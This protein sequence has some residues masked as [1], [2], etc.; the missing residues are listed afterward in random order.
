MIKQIKEAVR[1]K[2][3]LFAL[4]AFLLPLLFY[5]NIFFGRSFGFDCAPGI[6]GK[7]LGYLQ[8]PKE[9]NVYCATIIDPGAY[10]WQHPAQWSDVIRHYL[11]LEAPI[12]TQHIGLGFPLAANFQSGA[13]FILG[14]PFWF[15][16][17][18]SKGNLFHLDMF[19]VFRYMMMS[20]GMYLFLRSFGLRRL[21]CYIGAFLYFNIGYFILIPNI[22]HH[23]VDML[24][25]FVGWA[26]NNLYFSQQ[27]KWVGIGILILGLS[28]LAG[29][30]EASI[31]TLF[32]AG[33]YV[34][35]LSLILS[36]N[37]MKMFLYGSGSIVGALLLASLL[38]LPGLEYIRLGMTIHHDTSSV[39]KSIPT[40]Y[41]ST[42]TFPELFGGEGTRDEG[43]KMLGETNYL[44]QGW[45]YIGFS[46]IFFFI[47]GVFM[48]PFFPRIKER[49]WT[50]GYFFFTGLAI[51]LALQQYNLLHIFIFE[52]FPVFAQT[53]FSK[54]SGA[55]LSFSII[56]AGCLYLATAIRYRPKNIVFGFA[57]MLGICIYANYHYFPIVSLLPF[58][59]TLFGCIVNIF[60]AIVFITIM[61]LAVVLLKN[62][63]YALIIVFVLVIL[64]MYSYLPKDGDMTRHDSLTSVPPGIRY[65]IT[66]KDLSTRILGIENILYPDLADIYGLNDMRM[67]DAIWTKRTYIFYK[68]FFY[69]PDAFRIIGINEGTN[70]QADILRNP[71]FDL[72]SVKYILSYSPL[73]SFTSGPTVKSLMNS[74]KDEFNPMFNIARF[75][76]KNDEKDVVFMHAPGD[77]IFALQKPVGAS[78][79][80]LYPMLDPTIFG[81]KKGDGITMVATILDKNGKVLATNKR[82]INPASNKADQVWKKLIVGPIPN[83]EKSYQVKLHL[84]TLPGEDNAFDGVGWG[85]F[86]WDNYEALTA[87]KYKLVY[88]GEMNV[89]QKKDAL[90]RLH[91]VDSSYCV[92]PDE[93]NDF[94]NVIKTMKVYAAKIRNTA[95]IE[96]VGC[97]DTLTYGGPRAITT[98]S[99][100]DNAITF[101]YSA[102][103]PQ[104]IVLQDAYY[105]GWKAYINGE[106][107]KIDP[108]NITFRGFHVPAGENIHVEVRYQP[109]SFAIGLIIS[110]LT[111]GVAVY[112]ARSKE[113]IN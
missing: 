79:F 112:F 69:E 44:S 32:F 24:L 55:L 37:K 110:L 70:N 48:I 38:Y 30:P 39:I 74:M 106:E 40:E 76:I 73:E 59:A 88:N 8:V 87:Q 2:S 41:L 107:T 84:Q 47:S 109:L 42:L 67:L 60:Y 6:T 17:T 29:M 33:M 103:T 16:F 4:L 22:A 53:Q 105:P 100:Q 94:K 27:K 56:T 99:Y 15:L 45:N 26:L 89:Y 46:A 36:R 83:V 54:Y 12:W 7:D 58:T 13:F 49:K 85:G 90:P 31:F 18:I 108:V 101:T 3:F 93:R 86:Y 91:F 96:R 21:V 25:P 66:H 77:R 82:F 9:N 97:S 57:V 78:S 5:G 98:A 51:L 28:L 75:K 63:R 34:L 11:H 95:I 81:S 61:T 71:F 72:F 62:K 113:E 64:E 68:T 52:Q 19:F 111:L 14:F 102:K 35:V 20:L 23:S 1:S 10:V 50:I 65:L 80:T 104:Y 43:V 92:A